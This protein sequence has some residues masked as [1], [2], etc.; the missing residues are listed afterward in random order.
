MDLEI[1]IIT[2]DPENVPEL[3]AAMDDGG[4]AALL[5]APGC[6]SVKVLPGVENPGNVLFLVEWDSAEAHAA[7]KDSPGFQGFRA[8]CAPVFAKSKGGSMEHFR[9]R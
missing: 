4:S 7:A 2:L 3:L 1:A 9:M 6:R 8:A 5:S